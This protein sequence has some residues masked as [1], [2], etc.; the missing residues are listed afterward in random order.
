M[1]EMTAVVPQRSRLAW[2]GIPEPQPGPLVLAIDGTGLLVRCHRSMGASGLTTSGGVPTGTL[3]GFIGSLAKKLRMHQPDYAVVAW[4]GP[5]SRCWRRKIYPDYKA[6]RPD[7]WDDSPEL[8][9]CTEFCT[10]AGIRQ[11]MVPGFE[12]DDLLASIWRTEDPDLPP[13]HFTRI[14]SDDA[15]LL[16]LLDDS[17]TS[18]TG[19]SYEEVVLREDVE[20][21]WGVPPCWLARVRALSG[22]ESDNIPGLPGIGPVKAARMLQSAMGRWPLPES[23]LADPE[24]RRLAAAWAEVTDL[25]H[26]A[27]RAEHEPMVKAAQPDYFFLTGKAEWHREGS[28]SLRDFLSKYELSVLSERLSKG[29]LW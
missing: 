26:A 27:H 15:D 21:T 9:R 6:N 28:D 29:R 1:P 18:V 3:V 16:Q 5:G 8:R 2:R 24:Q 17:R 20:S 19:L 22:D 11:V 23:I 7:Q 12:A 14:V 10:A 25:V 4:D 13:P